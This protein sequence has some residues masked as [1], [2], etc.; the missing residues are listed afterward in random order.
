MNRRTFLATTAAGLG[1]AA[2]AQKASGDRWDDGIVRYPDPA[3]EVIDQTML[4]H[5]FE[6][7]RLEKTADAAE[8]IRAMVVR[9]APLIGSTAAFGMYLAALKDPSDA[10]LNS[11]AQELFNTLSH[12]RT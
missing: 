5:R 3:V 6:I 10:Y 11:A 2:L 1:S 7:S 12:K 4:P 8:A 9:G